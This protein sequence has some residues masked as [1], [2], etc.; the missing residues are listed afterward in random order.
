MESNCREMHQKQCFSTSSDCS[1]P[2]G[3]VNHYR[4]PER[5]IEQVF[6]APTPVRTMCDVNRLN[7]TRQHYPGKQGWG[8]VKRTTKHYAGRQITTHPH[9]Y[10]HPVVRHRD[11][12]QDESLEVVIQI[13]RYWNLQR[14]KLEDAPSRFQ[15][16]R[17]GPRYGNDL[18]PAPTGPQSIE[19]DTISKPFPTVVSRHVA[20]PCLGRIKLTYKT[21][22]PCE[23]WLKL[24]LNP[25]RKYPRALPTSA[26]ISC[27]HATTTRW[28]VRSIH[29]EMVTITNNTMSTGARR[30]DVTETLIATRTLLDTITRR[31]NLQKCQLVVSGEWAQVLEV[32]DHQVR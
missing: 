23:N 27:S 19:C 16:H 4:R 20:K 14:S 25:V 26:L 6:Q 29:A 8:P 5:R 15:S 24:N 13:H 9:V 7:D 17:A 21:R 2:A 30:N 10:V 22:S 3:N 28:L 31:V 12:R 11:R 18:G 1:Q 32:V